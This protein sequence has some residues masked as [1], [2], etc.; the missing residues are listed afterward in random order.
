MIVLDC[1][2]WPEFDEIRICFNPIEILDLRSDESKSSLWTFM[3]SQIGGDNFD[4]TLKHS[5]YQFLGA[6]ITFNQ[7]QGLRNTLFVFYSYFMVLSDLCLF[8]IIMT[9][10][11]VCDPDLGR[12]PM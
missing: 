4:Y 6:R 1:M 12:Y 8:V 2:K 5:I 7:E 11:G 9:K 10:T 3:A